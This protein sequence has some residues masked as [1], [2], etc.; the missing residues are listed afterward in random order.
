MLLENCD[1]ALNFM[2]TSLEILSLRTR[3]AGL[4]GLVNHEDDA[5][6]V[7]RSKWNQEDAFSG[8]Y[9]VSDFLL[10]ALVDLLVGLE[11]LSD[12]IA[13]PT[14]RNLLRILA[15]QKDRGLC[16]GEQVR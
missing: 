8:R 2:P 16:N 6:P 1:H 13:P 3:L 12:V 9:S 4:H 11:V 14:P 7:C 15:G 10:V 5:I